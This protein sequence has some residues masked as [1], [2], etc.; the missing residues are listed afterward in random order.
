MTPLPHVKPSYIN[1]RYHYKVNNVSTGL[2]K[3]WVYKQRTTNWVR[4]TYTVN[5]YTV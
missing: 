3:L 5:S 2:L 4:A 1:T